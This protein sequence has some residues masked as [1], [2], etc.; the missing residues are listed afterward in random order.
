M[1]HSLF[2]ICS[3]DAPPRQSARAASSCRRNC[4]RRLVLDVGLLLLVEFDDAAGSGSG[5]GVGG[6][7][8]VGGVAELSVL[9]WRD[10]LRRFVS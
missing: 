3:A 10:V 8:G 1:R 5:G 4:N 2:S 9:G 7:D 6:G